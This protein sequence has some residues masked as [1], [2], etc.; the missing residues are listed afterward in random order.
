MAVEKEHLSQNL[1]S[2]FKE[3]YA[4]EFGG[5]FDPGR[6]MVTS[7]KLAFY[8][9]V[10]RT[11]AKSKLARKISSLQKFCLYSM[12]YNSL[13]GGVHITPFVH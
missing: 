3:V 9:S 5:H 10:V 12:M 11:A 2:F 8:W 6:S 13:R 7:R 1:P 4:N